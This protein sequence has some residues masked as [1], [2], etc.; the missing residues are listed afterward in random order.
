MSRYFHGLSAVLFYILGTTVFAAYLLEKNGVWPDAAR[1]WM[2][3]VML[4]LLACGLLYGGL[5]LY[6][7]VKNASGKSTVLA[8]MLA[9]ISL[10]VFSSFAILTFWH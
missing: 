8:T 5:S 2:L 10:I 9:V 3:S 7:S 6:L 1:L 4:P